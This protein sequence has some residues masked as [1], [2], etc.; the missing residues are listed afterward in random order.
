MIADWLSASGLAAAK[1]IVTQLVLPPLPL[2]ALTLAGAWRARRGRR[3]GLALVA[4]AL[5]MQW[6]CASEGFAA[7]L[8]RDVL[9]PPPALDA[10]A[11]TALKAR[12]QGR[13]DIAIV[14]LGGGVYHDAPELGADDLQPPSLQ[15]LRYGLWLARETGIPAA[16]SGGAGWIVRG[17]TSVSEA[18]VGAR[19][20]AQEFGTPLRWIEPASRDTRENALDTIAL[21]APQGIRE[22]VLVTHGWHMPRALRE[23]R[24]AARRQGVALRIDAAPMGLAPSSDL[25]ATLW[26]PSGQGAHDV[27]IALRELLGLALAP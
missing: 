25:R 4:I 22:I 27:A 23:F 13:A 26:L 12:A 19:I 20:A 18:S 7:W 8:Q 14:V 24:E 9:R 2:F 16:M 6:L 3:G 17:D 1:P 15:R 10:A 21:L 5:A 11:R